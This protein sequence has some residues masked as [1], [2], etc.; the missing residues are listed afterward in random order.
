MQLSL[1]E[2]IRVSKKICKHF[3]Q[4][5]PLKDE[6]REHHFGQVHANAHLGEEMADDAAMLL[7]RAH[8][9]ER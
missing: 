2:G 4:W 8:W 1:C 3:Q 5:A 7:H 6:C 9:L